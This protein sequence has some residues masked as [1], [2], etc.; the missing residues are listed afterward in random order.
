MRWGQKSVMIVPLRARGRNLGVLTL[1]MSESSR[2]YGE[3]DL[4]L[5]VEMGSTG[6]PRR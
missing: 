6:G 2:R 3:D 4:R 1:V 5:A